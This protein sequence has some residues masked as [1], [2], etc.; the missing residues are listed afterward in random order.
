[1]QLQLRCTCLFI[2]SH[3]GCSDH[4]SLRSCCRCRRRLRRRS[5]AT[6]CGS[7]M[8]LNTLEPARPW[9][10]NIYTYI[11]NIHYNITRRVFSGRVTEEKREW[12]SEREAKQ[13]TQLAILVESVM[14]AR[15]YIYK[16]RVHACGSATVQRSRS[17]TSQIMFFCFFAISRAILSRW[18]VK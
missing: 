3:R 18:L 12:M 7:A 8:D 6:K 10:A 9:H 1:M 13:N 2:I 16:C 14:Y 11:Y 4:S 17:I 5:S 15:Y